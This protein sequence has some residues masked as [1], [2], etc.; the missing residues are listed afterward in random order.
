MRRRSLPGSTMNDTTSPSGEMEPDWGEPDLNRVF[1]ALSHQYL[2]HV[3]QAL[4]ESTPHSKAG[5][6]PAELDVGTDDFT[7]FKRRLVH[8]HL[9]KLTDKGYSEWDRKTNTVRRGENFD[10]IAPIV[11]LMREHE[12]ELPADWP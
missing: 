9:P 2:C 12:M 4:E 1:D 8:V 10:E 3:L 6:V 5:F 7:A 11:T